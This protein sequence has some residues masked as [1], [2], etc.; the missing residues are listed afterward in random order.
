L[1]I[2]GPQ[3]PSGRRYATLSVAFFVNRFQVSRMGG[4]EV[5]VSE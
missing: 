5:D 4:S 1:Q 2:S 3:G